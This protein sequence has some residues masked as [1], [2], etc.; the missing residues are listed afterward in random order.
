MR[1]LARAVW[2]VVGCGLL[3]GGGVQPA[4][5]VGPDEAW[6]AGN[7]AVGWGVYRRLDLLP[8]LTQG[9]RT[10]QFSSFAR[11]GTNNDGFGGTFSCLRTDGPG[12]VIA[13]DRGAGEVESVWFTRDSGTVSAT[14]NITVVL[15]GVT[16]LD[17]GLQQVVNGGVG[18]PFVWPLVSNA[19]QTSGGVTI[20]VPMAY[21]E[22]MRIATTNNPVF[23]HVVYREFG[24]AAGVVR[25]DPA[26]PA[27]DVINRLRGAGSGDPKPAQPGASTTSVTV[28]PPAGGVSTVASL[29]GPAAITAVRLRIPDAA[30]TEATLAGLRVRMT[31]DGRTTVDSPVGEFFG[32]GLGERQVRALMFS[33][34]SAPGGWYGAWWMMPYASSATVALVNTTGGTVFG[35]RAEVTAAPN[36][37]WT[38]ELGPGGGSGYFTAQSRRGA[39]V[40]ARDWIVADQRG[41]GRFVGVSQTVRNRVAGGNERGYLEGDERIYVDGLLSP[42]WH[43]T[44]TEDYYESGWYFNRGEYSGVFTG[45]TGHRVRTGSC[46]I[47]C[48]SM[49]RLHI[50]DAIPYTSA[51]RFG[52]EHG[53]QNDVPAEESSTAFLYTA[54]RAGMRTTDT[55]VTGDAASRNVHGYT[56][57]AAATQTLLA[58]VYEGDDDHDT[59]TGSVRSTGG[60]V[61]FRLAVDPA[62][63]GVR[64][65]RTSDQASAYQSAAVTVDGA[66][67]GTWVQ[68][69]GNGFQR[70][71]D[72]EYLLPTALTAGKSAITIRLVP[73]SPQWT[74]A[75]YRAVSLVPPFA[76]SAAPAKVTGLAVNP[77]RVHAIPLRWNESG[78]NVGVAAYRIYASSD[79]SAPVTGA[80]LVGTS[81]TNQFRHGP[82][83]P[84]VTRFYRILAVDPSGN[85][86][87]PSDVVSATTRSKTLSDVDNDARDDAVVFTQGSAADVLTA[88]ST[89]SAFGP[90][91]KG[92]DFFSLT[93][94]VPLTGDVNGDGRADIITFTRGSAADVWVALSTSDGFGPSAKWHDFFA[95]DT[96]YPEVG[97]VNGDGLTDIITFTRGGAGDVW[98]ALSTGTGFGP[99][100]KWHDTFCLGDEVPAVGDFDGDGRDDVVTFTRG[101]S[102]RAFVALSNGVAFVQDAWMWHGH[103]AAGTE[104]PGAGDF[105][106]DGR[107]DVVTFTRGSAADVY[108]SLSDGGRF[109]QDGVKWHDFFATGEEA[110]GIGD[111]NG[112]GKADV[113]TFTRGTAADVYAALSTG[114][115][116]GPG[117][118][119][120]DQLALGGEIPRPS[121]LR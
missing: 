52:I 31:F 115:G 18:A 25:F 4:A 15:D 105:D 13:E 70:W 46:A 17:A 19:D 89:G 121:L 108:V 78:D 110:P 63:Q 83:P 65:R 33:M 117:T 114:T 120:H 23:Y 112:D 102:A 3:L 27:T 106:G 39:T 43:G 6:V 80:N 54:T 75:G 87:T 79:P 14:G 111:V 88:R 26:D 41:R 74:G 93:G 42:Q 50:G 97:D 51:L 99:G 101:S 81:T 58:A 62:N 29:A 11:S 16:V 55:V 8:D 84:G 56:E 21:R 60:A 49:Y 32:A 1:G 103:F 48:D 69:L 67:A 71:L 109:V 96:E 44:G 59:V 10:R 94:E 2:G 22:S 64:L 5:G 104:L 45:D 73:S 7:G 30:A 47:E 68:P 113:L 92:H 91:T 24:D 40:P 34:D 38:A 9:A 66:A 72:D 28:S 61:S 85:A 12:C 95:M 36:A 90:A 57:S 119:W 86:G 37:K 100:I 107:D 118:K 82:L 116:F 76:D 98:V 35:V 53:A 20:K 77:G